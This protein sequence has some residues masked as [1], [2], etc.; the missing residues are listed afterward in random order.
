MSRQLNLPSQM[1][2]YAVSVQIPPLTNEQ[3]D[4]LLDGLEGP[5][6]YYNASWSFQREAAATRPT[7][8]QINWVSESDLPTEEVGNASIDGIQSA[9]NAAWIATKAKFGL[10]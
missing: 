10:R 9:L 7:I 1:K 4:H 6:G 2:D 3:R 5:S 8:D